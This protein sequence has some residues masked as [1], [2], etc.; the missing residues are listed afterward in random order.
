MRWKKQ[1]LKKREKEKGRKRRDEKYAPRKFFLLHQF[2]A[3]QTD[4]RLETE[5]KKRREGGG[6]SLQ[7]VG[8]WVSARSGEQLA[9]WQK[10]IEKELTN[11]EIVL[12]KLNIV[13]VGEEKK[14]NFGVRY[15]IA[16]V[17]G[18][19]RSAIRGTPTPLTL[20]IRV[21]GIFNSITHMKLMNS[22]T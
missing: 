3:K 5:K 8:R 11:V 10:F 19:K 20:W 4:D 7:R 12:L 21:G 2:I 14:R 18:G 15:S 13:N 6:G 22:F 16:I 17:G 9:S 1:R